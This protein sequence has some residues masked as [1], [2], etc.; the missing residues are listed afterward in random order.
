[1][2]GALEVHEHPRTMASGHPEP[3]F[4]VQRFQEAH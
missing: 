3:P 1:M 4:Q 2:R